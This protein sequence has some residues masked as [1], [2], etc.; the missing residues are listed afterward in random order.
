MHVHKG[1]LIEIIYLDVHKAFDKFTS[2]WVIL[3]LAGAA[4]FCS[5]GCLKNWKSCLTE[6][7][8]PHY[9][10][11]CSLSYS[12]I[13]LHPGTSVI[14][15]ECKSNQVSPAS[16]LQWFSP[17]SC[18]SLSSSCD[19]GP[20]IWFPVTFLITHL[21]FSG[22]SAVPVWAP[23]PCGS[24]IS[25]TDGSTWNSDKV[26]IGVLIRLLIWDIF[27]TDK[28]YFE[29]DLTHKNTLLNISLC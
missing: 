8:Q 7:S 19:K 3:G 18:R 12:V 16:Y 17:P 26:A 28:K 22:C 4:L 15:Q 21:S 13:I 1:K 11:S 14:F 5:E 27:L 10:S 20:M 25:K 2:T 9:W 23:V 24:T 29:I 6:N